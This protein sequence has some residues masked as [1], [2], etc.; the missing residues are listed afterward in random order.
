MKSAVSIALLR[1][2]RYR[3]KCSN[4]LCLPTM[5]IESFAGDIENFQI[6]YAQFSSAVVFCVFLSYLKDELA[7]LVDD[8]WLCGL[9]SDGILP[10]NVAKQW[11]KR[12]SEF[13]ALN[14]KYISTWIGVALPLDYSQHMFYKRAFAER[15]YEDVLCIRFQ[16]D[17][18]TKVR[19]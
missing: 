1:H 8:T 7:R 5:K 10:A 14:Y 17:K 13:P 15:A 18:T 11:N 16:E 19:L 9:Q 3:A 6:F 4:P 12:I 2:Q